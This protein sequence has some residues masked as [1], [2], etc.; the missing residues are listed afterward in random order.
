MNVTPKFVQQQAVAHGARLIDVER[1][2]AGRMTV[3]MQRNDESAYSRFVYDYTQTDLLR[4]EASNGVRIT[5]LERYK[6]NGHVRYAASLIDNASP[7]NRRVRSI[8]RSSTMANAPNG[9]DAWFGI[10]AKEVGGPVDVGLADSMAYQPLSVLKLIPHLYVMNLL[11][12]DP[13]LDLL[14][15]PNGISWTA[16]KGKPD[17]IYCPNS[18]QGTADADVLGD[19]AHD[20][21]ARARRVA[22]PRTRGAGQQV[23]APRRSTTG[24]MPWG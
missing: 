3:I 24:S 8:W 1:P 6:K 16:L 17:E 11:D 15:Q 4:F 2:K 19:A 5:D 9:N 7:E 13:G 18:M 20:A 14:D 21:H 10:Y 22:Q 23:R 12:N